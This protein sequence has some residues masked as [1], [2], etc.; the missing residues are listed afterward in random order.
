MPAPVATSSIRV[1]V[2]PIRA[3]HSRAAATMGRSVSAA[4]GRRVPI[5]L[6]T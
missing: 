2:T 5:G 4:T 6:F 3:K 1:R